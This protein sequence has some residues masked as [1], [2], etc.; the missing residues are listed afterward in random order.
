ML[1]ATSSVFPADEEVRRYDKNRK[2]KKVSNEEWVSTTDSDSRITKMK[3]GRTHL[4]YKAEHVVD[5]ESDLITAAEVRHADEGDAETMVDSVIEAQINLKECGCDNTVEEVAGDKGYHSASN[6]ELS[7]SLD[8]RT[9]IPEPKRRHK[10]RWTDKPAEQKKAVYAN[11]RRVRRA[12]SKR[13]QRRRSEVCERT[14]AHVCN[15]GGMRRTWLRGLSN[16]KKRY[17]IAAAAHNL[18]RILRSL[19]GIGKPRALQAGGGLAA[20]VYLVICS[21]VARLG[22]PHRIWPQRDYRLCSIRATVHD[23]RLHRTFEESA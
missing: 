4:A 5:L 22:H 23:H 9:Y 7:D 3:D 6:L 14:F 19:F 15:S 16:V 1:S 21:I 18:G 13:L 17:T 11:R 12:K 2:N 8:L 20:L 10:S